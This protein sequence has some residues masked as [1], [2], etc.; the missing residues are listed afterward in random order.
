MSDSDLDLFPIESISWKDAQ[1]FL[2]KLNA[3]AAGKKSGVKYRLPTEA[4]WE[5]SCRGGAEAK[6]PFVLACPGASLCSTQANFDGRHPYGGAQEGPNLERSCK[7]GSY[8]ANP[9]RHA[10]QRLGVV[11]RL[12]CRGLLW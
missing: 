2:K 3:L 6:Y 12:V 4:E 11:F 9:F 5:Y 7:V 10:R 8:E 1:A